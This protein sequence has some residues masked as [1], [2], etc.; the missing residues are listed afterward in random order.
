MKINAYY[1]AFIPDNGKVSVIF[2]DVPGC[3]TWGENMEHAFAMAM[4]ALEGHLGALAD[5]DDPIP[6]PSSRAMAL[7]KLHAMVAGFGMGALPDDTL[8]QM[9]PIREVEEKPA[10]VNVSFSQ[11]TLAMIDRKAQAAGMTRSGFLSAAA[12]AFEN[13]QRG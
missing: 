2:P 6:E 1:A 3:T 7:T 11:S 9:V 8:L 5:D 4:D 10:R 13:Q 12:T